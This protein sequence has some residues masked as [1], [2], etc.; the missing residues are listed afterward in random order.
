MSLIYEPKGR[1]REYAALALNIY[2]GC[3]DGSPTGPCKYC[4]A[5]GALHKTSLDFAKPKP[6]PD[7][8]DRLGKELLKSPVITER[9][10]LS[11]SC[12]PYQ[13]LDATLKHTR[14][15]IS[16]LHTAGVPVQVLTKGG[17]LALRDLDL[18]TKADAFASTLTFIDDKDSRE[19]EPWAASPINR[20]NTL[21]AFHEAGIPTWVS[22][23]P[24][25][26][27]AQTLN[28]IRMTHG[29]VDLYKVGTLN[30]HP[31]AKEIDWSD[32]AVKAKTLLDVLGVSY[33]FKLDLRPY[34]P[35]DVL[36]TLTPGYGL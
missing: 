36:A 10:L 28:L 11:F 19:W 6:R 8:I 32:F 9:V 16:L 2:D 14:L 12:D 1:A 24:V 35:P 4:Y 21:K 30:H 13:T 23:E 3:G 29:Y 27:P 25:I 7:F 34:L 20:M 22:L 31:L 18:F 26:D 17:S 5:S 15:A 33:Y